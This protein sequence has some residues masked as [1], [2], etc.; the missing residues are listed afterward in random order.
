MTIV[1][2]RKTAGGNYAVVAS[3]LPPGSTSYDDTGLADRAVNEW[4]ERDGEETIG[5]LL[6]RVV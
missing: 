6:V 3:N 2:E 1:V 5:R 4:S